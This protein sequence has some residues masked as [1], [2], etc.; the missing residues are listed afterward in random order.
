MKF[1][2]NLEM[3]FLLNIS[4]EGCQVQRIELIVGPLR[5]TGSPLTDDPEV[6]GLLLH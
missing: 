4:S 5:E 2:Q 1:S 6:P 3:Q